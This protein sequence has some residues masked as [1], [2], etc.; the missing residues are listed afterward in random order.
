HPAP[1][2]LTTGNELVDDNLGAVDEIA[3]LG[4]PDSQCGW[5]RRGI[6]IF[7]SEYTRLRQQGVVDSEM[8]SVPGALLERNELLAG[9]GVVQNGMSV[10]EG[11]APGILTRQADVETVI[12]Q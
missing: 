4:L 2:G 3:E 10:E 1:L 8:C 6:T 12:Q 7:K 11:T 5:I 9:F